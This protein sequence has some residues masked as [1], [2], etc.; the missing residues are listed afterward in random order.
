MKMIFKITF[1]LL[2]FSFFNLLAQWP[3]YSHQHKLKTTDA[4]W[5]QLTLPL[6]AYA[7]CQAS[8]HDVRVYGLTATGDT[9]E[10]PY[11]LEN[12][13]SE[14]VLS[15]AEFKIINTSQAKG[16]Y[17]YTFEVPSK[18]ALNTLH[19]N[20]DKA[21]F[22]WQ[23]ELDGSQNQQDWFKLVS[24]YRLVG[25]QNQYKEF[26]F[27]TVVFP[28]AKYQFLRLF[29]PGPN[30]PNLLNAQLYLEE[31]SLGIFRD[32]HLASFKQNELK[33]RKETEITLSLA[34]VSPIS[35][36][37]LYPA[38]SL[39]FY[40]PIRVAFLADSVQ[41][42]KGWRY[43]YREV[44]QGT[45]HSFNQD[46][47][48]FNSTLA[49]KLKIT[50][51]NH[52][53]APLTIDSAALSGYQHQLIC[54]LKPNKQ[55]FL[56][57]G[58]PNAPAPRYDLAQFKSSI[59]KNRDTVRVGAAT[60]IAQENANLRSAFDLDQIWLWLALGLIALV[61]IVFSLKMMRSK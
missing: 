25:V 28:Q 45:F 49:Q 10:A 2:V 39:D 31:K 33:K 46:A 20:F 26:S 15:E 54:R 37:K 40:R 55:Y 51:I 59:P 42:E 43:V 52:D 35:K 24:S 41:T 58:W 3:N 21:N 38:D 57:Y 7:H 11:L 14:T 56:I 23:V 50:I 47:F 17:F 32:Y 19:L 13:N 22:N 1:L 9:I 36:L 53:N 4:A 5:Q 44:Y 30:K 29:I 12:T 18:L 61:L 48:S 8:L 27:T 34:Q 16:G 60:K 6:E